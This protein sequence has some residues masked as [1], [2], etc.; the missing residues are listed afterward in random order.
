MDVVV[1]S[2]SEE[3]ITQVDGFTYGIDNDDDGYIVGMDCNDNDAAIN[4]GE[5]DIACDGID[6]DCSGSDK[7]DVGCR[8]MD[9]DGCPENIDYDDN[10]SSVYP[11][12]PELCDKKDND[13]NGQ[14]DDNIQCFYP[15]H[16]IPDTGISQC[17]GND[18]FINP[19]PL[20]DEA[21]YGQD[22]TYEI[23][24]PSY[25]KLGFQ[26]VALPYSAT[27]EDGWIM[28]K[29]NITGLIWELK[30]NT[31]GIN[32]KYN[33]YT[34]C[35]TEPSGAVGTCGDGT[36]TEDFITELNAEGYGGFSD[37]RLP[38]R[39]ELQTIINYSAVLPAID[40]NYFPNTMFGEYWSSTRCPESSTEFAR[41]VYF[42][43]GGDGQYG[44]SAEIYVRAVRGPMMQ[45]P[46]IRFIDNG[47]E[48]ITDVETGL[49]WQKATA[50]GTYLWE[51]ALDYS[52]NLTLAGYDD[53]RLP[54]IK[55]LTSLVSDSN[56]PR[57]DTNFFPDTVGS[58][59][60][61][62]SSFPTLRPA[63]NYSS[64]W[65]VEFDS[66]RVTTLFGIKLNNYYVRAVRGIPGSNPPDVNY[67]DDTDGDN[68]NMPD[69][70]EIA[71]FGDTSRDGAGDY[72]KD[73]LADLQE[74]QNGT[75]PAD[76]DTD[77][78][79]CEDGPEVMGGRNPLDQDPQGDLNADCSLD[80]KDAISALQ[81]VS[82]IETA[83]IVDLGAEINGDGKIGLEEAIFIMQ[84]LA[85]TRA[86]QLIKSSLSYDDSPSYEEEDLT[87]LVNGFADFAM[88]FYHEIVKDGTNQG[89]NIFLSTYSIENALAL[90]W[91]GAKNNTAD[92]M[93]NVLHLSL[94]E[95]TF[96]PT[97]NALN[98]DLNSRDNQP[99][100][101]GDAFQMNIVNAIWSR[102]GYPFLATYLDVI[103]QNYNAGIRA[104]D[105]RSDPDGSRLIINQWV[106]E[107]TNE[108]IKDLLP[109]MSITPDTALVLTNAI[110]FK[111]SWF[112]KFDPDNTKPGDFTLLDGTAVTA[113]MMQQVLDTRIFQ[114]ENYDAVEL[115]YVSSRFEE[116]EY[117]E[118]LSM[119]F[120][121]PHAGDFATVE[122]SLSKNTID[123]MVS[124][125]T[126]K[127][128]DLSLPKFEFE[129]EVSCKQ[130]L[131]NLGMV[132]A[133]E[134]LTADFSGMVNPVDSRPWIDQVYHKAF[135]AVDEEGTEA[136]AATAVVMTDTAVPEPI[137]MVLD[138]P[139]IFIIRDN[140]TGAILFM[141]RVL[142]P[143]AG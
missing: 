82:R 20:E 5:V 112:S 25:V 51:E 123:M 114:G 143:T 41:A 92:E 38:T 15:E 85:G 102:I 72:D 53:W 120:I 24:T 16:T 58:N 94:P 23:N 101:S 3:T 4:P 13:Q 95:I 87:A 124:S 45:S 93:A 91:A 78:D 105:F 108:K 2:S 44:T 70:W 89:K 118:E 59:Y 64:A 35:E 21:F 54:N 106:E 29:D 52:E 47:D 81:V 65:Y 79:G 115:P 17:F 83:S 43:E 100:P 137:V 27:P 46:D 104:L 6:Q 125:L 141:G 107:Q 74:Y 76:S 138:R 99:P 66:G 39:Q 7:I 73:A 40:T 60:W 84:K 55:E 103:A 122:D 34:W 19:C 126:M 1:T 56:S 110:Y 69:D 132:D 130:L 90:T 86:Q 18:S 37:W 22:A 30:T 77:D 136:A 142:D 109:E 31:T 62:S 131:Y 135:V 133:F 32:N 26:G 98:L 134:P 116:W 33:T 96:H 63:D 88:D 11:G 128:I 12:A 97:L 9:S 71:Y 119:L 140:I 127:E 111:A 8:D 50:P 113:Q 117:P 57:I 28:T 68:D 36:D 67:L 42:H 48:T 80:L 129:F 14:I 121:V 10:D 49:M 139:F 61:S 75:N